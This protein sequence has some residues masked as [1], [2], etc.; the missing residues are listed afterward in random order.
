MR[1]GRCCKLGCLPSLSPPITLKMSPTTHSSP[2]L[3]ASLPQVLHP[4]WHTPNHSVIYGPAPLPSRFPSLQPSPSPSISSAT[5]S[6]RATPT[7]NSPHR[8]T[9]ERHTPRP[10]DT[11]PH[12]PHPFTLL[13][14]TPT[15]PVPPLRDTVI[16]N[17]YARKDTMQGLARQH[18]G[19]G[20]PPPDDLIP[21]AMGGLIP[22][23]HD[24]DPDIDCV[25]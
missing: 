11:P 14:E 13:P 25:L 16:D 8:G 9:G 17:F 20:Y 6:R 4:R 22:M 24:E 10:H 19:L 15:T 3:P 12:H 5:P 18:E 23:H 2:L 1:F 7:T 21:T